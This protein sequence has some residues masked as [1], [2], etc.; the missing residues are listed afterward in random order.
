MAMHT[1]RRSLAFVALLCAAA[2]LHPTRAQTPAA[3]VTE[4]DVN[5]LKV[6]V[7]RRAGTPT[8]A[9]GLFFRGGVRN[10]TA[11]S[12]GIENLTLDVAANG[13]KNYPKEKLRRELARMGTGLGAT[14]GWD[15]SVLSMSSTKPSFDASWQIFA[16]VAMRPAFDTETLEIERQAIMT[17]LRSRTDSPEA[18]L[19]EA[20]ERTVF[21][22]HPY[23][24]NPNGTLE[25]VSKFTA[26]DL[27][28]YHKGLMQ[29]SR[30]LLV[31][32][33]DVE[34]AEIQKKVAA[35]FGTLSRG[36]YKDT[37]MP[38][39]SFEK[40]T[41][42]IVPKASQTDYVRGTFAA[43]AIGSSDYYAMRS[44]IA[45]LQARVF[46]E[47]RV[48]RNLSYAPD[49][50]L[51]ERAANTGF[52]SVSSV[53]PSESARVMLAEVQRLRSE[54]VSDDVLQ[55][56]S[57]FFLTN[58][59]LRQETNA[60]QAGELAQYEL[61]GGGWRNSLDF[62]ERVRRVT[63]AEV[64]AVAVKYMKNIRF[65]FVGSAERADR[66]AFLIQDK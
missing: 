39:P 37:P 35:A 51:D 47:V 24:L 6:L 36:Q 56:V 58:Y 50:D 48:R 53:D 61:T 29:T 12:A 26:A 16:D 4:L 1:F 33:G 9:V 32:V 7:K 57:G 27:A 43:P 65:V 21:A 54:P 41:L 15:Y 14:S 10:L 34:P 30:L 44:A 42:D 28:G 59:Y 62:L 60:A 17:G 3:Q 52:I 18:A 40:P 64:R 23:S 22:G 45:I 2:F 19:D 63:P 55:Q 20:N 49:A 8:V 25:A 31:V 66:D 46:Q 38:Q 13:S 11:K 5:G